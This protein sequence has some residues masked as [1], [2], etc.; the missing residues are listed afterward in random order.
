MARK[1]RPRSFTLQPNPADLP[2]LLARY[3]PPQDMG[4]LAAGKL[5]RAGQYTRANLSEIFEW[6][7]KGR[8]RSRLL[9][10]TDEEIEDALQLATNA[11]TERAAISVLQGLYGVDV[12]VASAILAMIYPERY[13]IIDFRALHALGNRIT[14]RSVDFFLIYLLYC[15]QLAKTHK[16][17][18]RNLDRALW[19]WSDENP[20]P[21][22]R[23]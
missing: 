13:T 11:K 6:K 8:G 14:D 17:S 19:R 23:T 2:A 5:I 3:G 15:R 9:R 12:P 20:P 22:I 21:T 1:P 4:A 16:L 7:T 18:L 10:N